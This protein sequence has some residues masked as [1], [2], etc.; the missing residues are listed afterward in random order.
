MDTEIATRVLH[1]LGVVLWIGGVAFVTTVLLRALRDGVAPEEAVRTFERIERGFARQ[2]RVTTLVVGAS[3]FHLVYRYDL[4]WRFSHPEY[5]WMHA[6]VALWALF[7]MVL[8]VLEPLFLHRWFMARG[9]RA[10]QSAFRLVL[11]FH[12]VLLVLSLATV[13]GAVAGSHGA[14]LFP[15][16]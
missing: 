12:W 10:P 13:A 14:F 5:W 16:R 1:V 7:T 11:G 9:A 15:S 4:W 2:S 8:F 3:G 6:M